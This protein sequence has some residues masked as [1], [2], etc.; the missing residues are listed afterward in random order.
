MCLFSGPPRRVAEGL[1]HTEQ[2]HPVGHETR[3]S[4]RV[5]TE[6]FTF[7]D[8]SAR[9][10][11]RN[12]E[13]RKRLEFRSQS[14]I[15]LLSTPCD[16]MLAS[17]RPLS[18]PKK[19]DLTQNYHTVNEANSLLTGLCYSAGPLKGAAAPTTHNATESPPLSLATKHET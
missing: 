9:I 8:D 4:M 16:Q 7:N 17:R 12:K 6:P 3:R 11:K 13:Q 14:L 2:T 1:A 10:K 18:H 19:V 15:S 5:I